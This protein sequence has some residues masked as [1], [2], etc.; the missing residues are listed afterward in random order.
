MDVIELAGTVDTINA[1]I[2]KYEDELTPRELANL[3]CARM[4]IKDTV[5]GELE[6]G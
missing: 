4:N 1:Y 6:D 2:K 5:R 3:R